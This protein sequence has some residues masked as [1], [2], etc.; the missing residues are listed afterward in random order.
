V[1]GTSPRRAAGILL[2]L[3]GTAA[4]VRHVPS[5][6]VSGDLLR[7][8]GAR[9]AAMIDADPARLGLLLDDALT[10]AHSNGRIDS[11]STLVDALTSG[12]IDYRVVERGQ[13]TA[14]VFDETGIVTGPVRIEVAAAGRVHHLAGVY[15]AVY[16]WRDGLWRLVAYHSSPVE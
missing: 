16:R 7:A 14:R 5:Q 11:K 4:C 1:G 2:V 12:R 13:V 9:A 3:A 15:T 8:D 10:Y 6:A